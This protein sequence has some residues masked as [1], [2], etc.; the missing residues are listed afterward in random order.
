MWAILE[1]N[2]LAF[3]TSANLMAAALDSN[4]ELGLL[5]TGGDVPHDLAHQIRDLMRAGVL[6]Q[7]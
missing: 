5:I 4:I 3:V 7:T 6:V 1:T 2:S